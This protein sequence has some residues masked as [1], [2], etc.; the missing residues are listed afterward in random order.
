V[1]AI[2]YAATAV[3]LLWLADRYVLP[4]SRGAAII[5]LL[6]PLC[7][8]GRALLTGRVYGPVEMPYMTRPL[9]DY[10]AALHVP[11]THN[12]TLADIAF[13]MIPW[14]EAVRR[15]FAE[16]EWPLWNR[17]M[18]CGDILAAEMQ[19][20]VY[21]PFTWIA[22]LLPAAVS[23]GYTGAI[24]FFVA[25]LG[26][27]LF[28]RELG[29]SMEA[30][31]LAAIGWM[32]SGPIALLILWPVGF[33][34]ALFP[35]ILLTTRRV[36]RD[37]SIRSTGLLIVAFVLEIVAGHPETLL[38]VIA[39]AFVYGLFEWNRTYK[40]VVSA[41]AA[42]VLALMITAVVLLPFLDVADESYDHLVRTAMYAKI[43]LKIAPGAVRMQTLRNLFPFMRKTAEDFPLERADAGS[44]LLA[45]AIAAPFAIRRRELK[46]FVPL[47]IVAFLAGV[48]AWPIAQLLHRLPLFNA[49]LNDRLAVAVPLALAVLAIV[50]IDTWPRWVIV[51]AM[52]FVI[53][54]FV[55]AA[56]VTD[57]PVQRARVFAD[58]APLVVA[59]IVVATVR[60]QIALPAL[61]ALTLLQRTIADGSLIPVHPRSIAY[62]RLGLFQPMERVA[63]PFRIAPTGYA[64]LSNTATLYGLEDVRGSTPMTLSLLNDTFPLWIERQGRSFPQV[65]DLTQPFLSMINVRFALIE[66]SA[67]LP[68]GWKE[69]SADISMRLIENTH[70]L[71]RAFIPRSVRFHSSPKQELDE[72]ADATDF[73]D[74][75]WLYVPGKPEDRVNGPGSVSVTRNKSGIDATVTM[76]RPGFVIISEAAWS[77][78]R[79][80]V[81]D[82]R[83]KELRANHAFLGVYVPAGTHSV[84]LR[85]LPQSF[86]VGRAISLATLAGIAI[87]GFVRR[88]RRLTPKTIMNAGGR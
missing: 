3:V 10:R 15:S 48:N 72:M 77:G 46:F 74:R 36:A 35:F 25:G 59:A 56:T 28:A 62:P 75:A 54:A 88:R 21:S 71:S 58:I 64:F 26:T 70:V 9:Y 5:L 18:F 67:P 43:P 85:Y 57:A 82:R 52:G 20:A 42:G 22:C 12:P 55:I 40:T 27:F 80:Y 86:V 38:H 16:G 49:T 45:L 1:T 19:P 47:T 53:Q 50:V 2:L 31:I 51:A 23:F 30:A 34:W 37:P 65:N 32:F 4:I 76:Q 44:I 69:V 68:P 33:A 81:D 84:H 11:E 60:K 73:A 39:I 29:A 83:V 66:L 79:A 41:V 78:W 17:F 6:L 24:A 61:I 63:E 7:F 14:R 8:T 13:Q 87:F